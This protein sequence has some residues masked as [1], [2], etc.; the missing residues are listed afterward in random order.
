MAKTII[1]KGV[2]NY[3]AHCG[4]CGCEFTYERVDVH[5]NYIRGGEF[6][7]CPHCGHECA[8]FGESGT[9]WPRERPMRRWACPQGRYRG[10]QLC[11][12]G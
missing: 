7:A 3:H 5:H 10:G 11:T 6:V 12:S 8:H 2:S 1:H 4:E 9:S